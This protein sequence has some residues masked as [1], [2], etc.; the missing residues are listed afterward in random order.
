MVPEN[1]CFSLARLILLNVQT[2]CTFRRT[3]SK[4]KALRW[5]KWKTR[6]QKPLRWWYKAHGCW[7][8]EANAEQDKVGCVENRDCAAFFVLQLVNSFHYSG[9]FLDSSSMLHSHLTLSS[10]VWSSL[11]DEESYPTLTDNHLDSFTHAFVASWLGYSSNDTRAWSC[12]TYRTP[13][14]TSSPQQ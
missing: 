14:C 12:W 6:E 8:T 2:I 11:D 3:Q 5:K 9:L 4:E 13:S 10:H 7:A 1:A